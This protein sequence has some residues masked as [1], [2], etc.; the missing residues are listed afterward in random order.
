M[1]P[2]KELHALDQEG[3]LRLITLGFLRRIATILDRTNALYDKIPDEIVYLCTGYGVNTV[4]LCIWDTMRQERFMAIS[5]LY[6]REASAAILVCD[7]TD[8]SSFMVLDEW[9]NEFKTFM[10]P[11]MVIIVVANK[12]DMKQHR[13]VGDEEIKNYAQLI[14]ADIIWTSAKT[15]FNINRLFHHV[16][17]RIVADRQNYGDKFKVITLGALGVGKS[18]IL[19]S[20]CPDNMPYCVEKDVY[21]SLPLNMR[22]K[23]SVSQ[24]GYWSYLT[25]ALNR[26]QGL[27]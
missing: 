12:M 7:V 24:A 20:K 25:S 5:A 16:A 21:V 13:K 14:N 6:Y 4:R 10:D 2:W 15:G 27:F 18:S 11:N 3:R 23:Q 8:H 22:C 1:F 19:D 17:Y 9:Y 26:L